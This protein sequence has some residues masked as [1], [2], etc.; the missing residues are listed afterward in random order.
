MNSVAVPS[1]VAI[2]QHPPG[3]LPD[4]PSVASNEIVPIHLKPPDRVS[5][6]ASLCGSLYN[7]MTS[8]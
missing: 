3:H 2:T 8:G 1:F 4:D 5:S 6:I 7:R